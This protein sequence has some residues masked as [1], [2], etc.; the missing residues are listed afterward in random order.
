MILYSTRNVPDNKAF[1][2]N[3][4]LRLP[5]R[6]LILKQQ[7]S[8]SLY[9]GSL[10]SDKDCNAAESSKRPVLKESLDTEYSG[11]LLITIAR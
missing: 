4:A 5:P 2:E 3:M 7:P 11:W 10:T 1:L 9:L 6:S 8:K